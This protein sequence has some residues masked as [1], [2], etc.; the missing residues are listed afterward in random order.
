MS[1]SRLLEMLKQSMGRAFSRVLVTGEVV[2]PLLSQ[3]GHFYFRLRDG[4]SDLKMVMWASDV[5][6]LRTLPQAG[7]Q[8]TVRGKL[9]VY[10]QRGELQLVASAL[11]QIGRGQTMAALEQLKQKLKTE[12]LFDRNRRPLPRFPKSIGVVTSAGSAVIHDIYQT[13][14]KRWPRS[15][16]ILSPSSVSGGS[17]LREL[18]RALARLRDRVDVVIVG[19]G[20][21][22]FEELSVFSSEALVRAVAEFPVPVVSAVGHGSDSTLLDLVADHTAPTPTGAAVLV[23][24]DGEELRETVL[25]YRESLTNSI[26]LMLEQKRQGL[27]HLNRVCRG[28]HPTQILML[29]RQRLKHIREKLSLQMETMSRGRRDKLKMKVAVLGRLASQNKISEAR[30]EMT[31]ICGELSRAVSKRLLDQKAALREIRAKLAVLGPQTA[32]ERGFALVSDRRGLVTAASGRTVGEELEIRFADGTF[33][34]KVCK[35]SD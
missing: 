9:D 30:S 27:D 21:G 5:R 3:R 34:V 26:A 23:T 12:G 17:A 24:P 15:E 6:G 25:A 32:L 22:S 11:M 13:V 2:D 20:G 16:I 7:S 10:P 1:V 8:V 4:T 18:P 28:R 19:R 29:Q 33:V 35:I 31:Q 14:Q